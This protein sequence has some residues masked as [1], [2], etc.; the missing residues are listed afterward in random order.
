MT[1]VIG[2]IKFGKKEHL[3]S[4]WHN[5]QM[6]FGAIDVFAQ[7]TEKERGDKFEGAFNIE[8]GQFSKLEYNHAVFGK[9]SFTPAPNTNGTIINFTDDP[10]FCFSSYALTSNCFKETDV[11]KIDE[12]MMEFGEY[13]L[14]IKEPNLFF[15]QV[16]SKLTEL[17]LTFGGKLASY[18]DFKKEGTID[19]NVFSKTKDL[20][21]QFEH[22][23]LIK[24]EQK[25]KEIFLEIGSIQDYCILLRTEVMLQTEFRV[26]QESTTTNN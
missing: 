24:T 11:H 26:K 8:N 2:L 18:M 25:Q 10:Y 14:A 20:Q 6:R 7:S 19:S 21:H 3:E 23:I 5:G 22:R 12:R 13:A 15:D 4:L 17:D 16:R 1:K 9:G